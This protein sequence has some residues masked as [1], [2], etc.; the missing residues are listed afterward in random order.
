[1]TR[2]RP[3]RIPTRKRHLR[4]RN[5]NSLL[6]RCVSLR[7]ACIG[8]S[9]GDS[10]VA[11]CRRLAVAIASDSDW[12]RV[13]RAARIYETW[14]LRRKVAV[15]EARSMGPLPRRALSTD[16]LRCSLLPLLDGRSA[17]C[18]ASV[19]RAWKD[20]IYTSPWG[21]RFMLDFTPAVDHLFGLFFR[22]NFID[23]DKL[24]YRHTPCQSY[25][26]G[27]PL[28]LIEELHKPNLLDVQPPAPNMRVWTARHRAL[29]VTPPP[30]SIADYSAM[31][32]ALCLASVRL[33]QRDQLYEAARTRTA[34]VVFAF[35]AMT[36]TADAL[37]LAAG[38]T[39]AYNWTIGLWPA[40]SP[41]W[42][43][44][45][46]AEFW[47]SA[48]TGLLSIALR[49]F[50]GTL[51]TANWPV[52][53]STR[54]AS[55][56]EDETEA[57]HWNVLRLARGDTFRFA[58]TL[59]IGLALATTARTAFVFWS[60]ALPLLV[61]TYDLM[62]AYPEIEN[63]TS[64]LRGVTSGLAIAAGAFA[65]SLGAIPSSI[66][67]VLLCFA[68]FMRPLRLI[69]GGGNES[70]RF[71]F[72]RG[73]ARPTR[74]FYLYLLLIFVPLVLAIAGAAGAPLPRYASQTGPSCIA[75]LANWL[76]A[77]ISAARRR[78]VLTTVFRPA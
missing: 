32:R 58:H 13:V 4:F 78:Y 12:K 64:R 2:L 71:L 35:W 23:G 43:A 65:V 19:S 59:I 39:L 55:E 45:A 28:D 37:S 33:R 30:F 41:L 54:S 5:K 77:R 27:V 66:V 48:S 7:C 16:I 25:C 15:I 9:E 42:H 63:L 56:L 60:T 1:M 21:D 6:A 73:N 76:P 22:I 50:P 47:T 68:L 62:R 69:L 67:A 24:R 61:L 31:G 40:F 20:V 75:V 46:L 34:F 18:A 49:R 51:T 70:T 74:F 8:M 38:A 57:V 29:V 72:G 52:V 44:L 17:I 53:V 36:L 14:V 3:S 26:A 10:L 11:G